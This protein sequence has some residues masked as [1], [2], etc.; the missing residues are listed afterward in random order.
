MQRTRKRKR[1]KLSNPGFEGFTEEQKKR[2]M[3]DPVGFLLGSIAESLGFQFRMF[4]RG[5]DDP[6]PAPMIPPDLYRKL[7]MLCHPDKHGNS[8]TATEVTRWLLKMR[9]ESRER[10]Q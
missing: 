3:V 7:L 4:G 9:I 6:A 8:E 2:M 10:E 1:K 5:G